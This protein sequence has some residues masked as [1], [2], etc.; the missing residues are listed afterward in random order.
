MSAVDK[1]MATNRYNKKC[2]EREKHVTVRK[3]QVYW[4][5]FPFQVDSNIQL[6]H[7]PT[8]VFGYYKQVVT[9]IATE[10]PFLKPTCA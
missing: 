6:W 4:R 1:F 8:S 2:T 5:A 7:Q 10:S 9:N 3:Q